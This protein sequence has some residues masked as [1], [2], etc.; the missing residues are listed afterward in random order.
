MNDV[1]KTN[2]EYDYV[3]I[4]SGFGGS[5]SALRLSQKGYKVLVIEKGRWY[6]D[7][8]FAATNWNLRRWI[9]APYVGLRGIMKPTFLKHMTVMSGVGVGGGSLTYGATLPTPKSS[10]F[11]T[12]S[13]AGLQSWEEL[14]KPHYKEALRM[15][16]AAENPNLT[17]ADFAMQRLAK[18]IDKEDQF[19]R[20]R[21]GVFFSE[22]DDKETLHADPY[23]DGKGP[24]RKACIEC[25]S[26]MSGCRHN[27]KNTLDKNYL[28]LAQQLGAEIIA[29]REVTDVIPAGNNDGSQGY[30]ISHSSS[31]P[32]SSSLTKTIRTKGIIFS[33]GVMGTVPLLLKLK[34]KNSLPNLSNRVGADI[35]TNNETITAVTSFEK[36]TNFAQGVCI[37]SI[38][39]PD[40]H[41]HIEPINYNDRSGA[42]KL[43]LLPRTRGKTIGQRFL[44]LLANVLK[45]PIANLRL[46]LEKDWGK[47]TIYLLFM[48]HL[49]SKV[50]L[51]LNGSGSLKSEVSEGPPPAFDIPESDRLTEKVERLINGKATSATSEF[52]FGAPTTGHV[53]GGAVIGADANQG[54]IN[55]KGLVFGYANMMVCDGSAMS[56]NPGV[57]PSLSIT[58]IS[59]WFMSQIDEKN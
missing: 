26:C 51:Q 44:S 45:S 1:S 10:F 52:I 56:A 40:E 8:D 2:E 19:H 28:Y 24:S 57:N 31:K 4:G 25:G 36:D 14:L 37:G 38:L 13:W 59:E 54:V 11:K 12:G 46:L 35:R 3:I 50:S 53:L 43:M 27:A 6:R 9:W 39:H 48:Q 55:D 20:S 16:G 42:W 5:V 18:E 47:K 34:A 17:E 7:Q 58:A 33:G 30:F 32:Y 21:V 29:E 49:D 41:S 15:L 22:S 23:F